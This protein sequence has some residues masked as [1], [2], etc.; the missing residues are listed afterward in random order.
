MTNSK[1]YAHAKRPNPDRH[2]QVRNFLNQ[3]GV[4]DPDVQRLVIL[5][6]GKTIPVSRIT[7]YAVDHWKEFKQFVDSKIQYNEQQPK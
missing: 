2:A 6:F 3:R 1:K 4:T 7:R 5:A